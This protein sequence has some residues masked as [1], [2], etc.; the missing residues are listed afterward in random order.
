MPEDGSEFGSDGI[1]H[2]QGT[3]GESGLSSDAR[4]E[5]MAAVK[6]A[7]SK[8]GKDAESEAEDAEANSI[9]PNVKMARDL[10]AK[11]KAAKKTETEAEFDAESASLKTIL[12]NREQV[13]R[14]KQKAA[15]EAQQIRWEAQQERVAVQREREALEKEK[16]WHSRLRSNPVQAVKEAG[17]DPEEFIMGLAKEG[18]PEGKAAQQQAAFAAKIRE[19]EEFKSS[20]AKQ[21]QEQQRQYQL[22]QVQQF[23]TGVE[24]QFIGHALNEDKHPHLTAMYQGRE[25]SL[26]AE[27]DAVADEYRE[28]TGKEA[29]VQEIA[30]YLEEQA[31]GW[32]KKL[33]SR[34]NSDGVSGKPPQGAVKGKTLSNRDAGE[35]RSLTGKELSDLDGDERLEAAKEAVRAAF[36]ASG[37]RQ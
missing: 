4:E 29:S 28:L 18:T 16:A 34:K 21:Q 13:A 11:D 3:E 33:Q 37:S 31:A 5:A 6:E 19:L 15:E 14:Q 10:R 7:I 22:S 1:V 35:R 20:Y 30:E 36:R 32:Y 8:T 26:L 25:K 2:E 24:Q 27:G 23:R 9:D 17:W 12:K